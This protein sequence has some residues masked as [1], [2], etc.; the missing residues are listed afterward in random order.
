M[1]RVV[2]S[3][4]SL[5]SMVL[6]PS[7]TGLVGSSLPVWC[8]A[9]LPWGLGTALPLQICSLVWGQAQ[10]EGATLR[11]LSSV[12]RVLLQVCTSALGLGASCS[13]ALA[14]SLRFSVVNAFLLMI[15]SIYDEFYW[16]TTPWWVGNHLY[17]VG[18]SLKLNN[19]VLKTHGS[20]SNGKMTEIRKCCKLN[21]NKNIHI[22]ILFNFQIFGNFL[23]ILLISNLILVWSETVIKFKYFEMYW[24]LLFHSIYDS[25]CT[26]GQRF[27]VFV[28]CSIL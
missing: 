20:R 28:V 16:D 11:L 12:L 14:C 21:S 2:G 18:L 10:G 26:W 7:R 19:K 5:L 27:S 1:L 3:G 17:I 23:N 6:S 13:P 22:N 4:C 9:V 25:S 8:H 24:D 15:F